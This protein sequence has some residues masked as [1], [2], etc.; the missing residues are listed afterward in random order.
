[1]TGGQGIFVAV[2]STVPLLVLRLGASFLRMGFRIRRGA[3]RFQRQLR[4]S[5]VQ[6]ELARRLAARYREHW[7]LRKF[8]SFAMKQARR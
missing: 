4:K 7:S 8:I 2:A 5:G 3:S 6:P 1:M